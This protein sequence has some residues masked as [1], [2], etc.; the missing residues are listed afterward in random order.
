[1]YGNS[2][3]DIELKGWCFYGRGSWKA[4]YSSFLSLWNFWIKAPVCSKGTQ[5]TVLSR[6]CSDSLLSR[7]PEFHSPTLQTI[8]F[9][10]CTTWLASRFMTDDEV[11]YEFDR[12]RPSVCEQKQEHV[13]RIVVI[14]YLRQLNCSFPKLSSFGS[15]PTRVTDSLFVVPLSTHC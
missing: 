6:S 3:C 11:Q 8:C 1:M 15:D 10:F 9:P 5:V 14:F 4:F 2:I 12:V 13:E 7:R